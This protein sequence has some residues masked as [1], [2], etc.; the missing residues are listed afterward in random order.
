MRTL[1]SEQI[2]AR[3]FRQRSDQERDWVDPASGWIDKVRQ[4]VLLRGAA[5]WRDC[6]W[7]QPATCAWLGLS[8]G[9]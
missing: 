8:H 5:T 9:C 6:I 4:I 3:W 7:R 1:D 2:A